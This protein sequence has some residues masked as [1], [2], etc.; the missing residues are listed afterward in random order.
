MHRIRL[1]IVAVTLGLAITHTQAQDNYPSRVVRMVVPFPPGS[2]TDLL[3]RLVTDQ[4]A[5]K[6]N[7]SVITENV[8]GASGNIG[9]A[10][11]FRSAPDGHT[12][13]LCPP[14]PIATNKFLFKDL[15][16]DSNRWV[17]ISWLTTVPYVLIARTSF[18]GDFRALMAHAK[19]NPGKVTAAM[20]G[21]GGTAHLSA[22]YLESVAG[23]KLVHVP[24]RGLGPA[25][26]DI[27]AGHVD[28]MFDTFTT[29]LPQ[30]QA[31][32][33]KMVAV[34][35]PQRQAAV[36]DVPAIA[37]LYPGYHSIT[38]FG[39]VAPP[40]TPDVL[41]DR[42]NRDVAEIFRRPEVR[43]RLDEMK[44]EAVGSSRAEAARFFAEEATLWGK[45]IETAKI[46]VQ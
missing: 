20:P 5:R 26:N 4:L 14:G 3:S 27:I 19:A 13:L 11:V 9:A 40:G 31:G 12:L 41:A 18:A 42:I 10:D 25:I 16:Y 29:S 37:E 22:A 30:H 39:I 46:A 2:G 8:P 24:Y 44:M 1:S 21:P 34:A 32:K 43:N 23:I 7:A 45:V 6:W 38:W 17:P 35:S 28:M 33:V 15:A 36:P